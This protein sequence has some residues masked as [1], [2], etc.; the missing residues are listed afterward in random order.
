MSPSCLGAE[1]GTPTVGSSQFDEF[2]ISV[3]FYTPILEF[4]NKLPFKRK[5]HGYVSCHKLVY[6][7]VGVPAD[8]SIKRLLEKR[9]KNRVDKNTYFPMRALHG[10]GCSAFADLS[11]YG[12][13]SGMPCESNGVGRRLGLCGHPD[14]GIGRKERN[15]VFYCFEVSR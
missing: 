5:R 10:L 12:C 14:F 11:Q 15:T 8:I 13:H 1:D 2:L 6:V 4:Y 3:G 7:R 9:K